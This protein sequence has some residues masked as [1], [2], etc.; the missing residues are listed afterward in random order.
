MAKTLL[1]LKE[2]IKTLYVLGF[3]KVVHVDIYFNNFK[4]S[5]KKKKFENLNFCLL[6][7]K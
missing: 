2:N 4:P 7:M 6:K 3:L 1:V 5:Y